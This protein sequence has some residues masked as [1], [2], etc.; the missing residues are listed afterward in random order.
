MWREGHK[1]KP[2]WKYRETT[3]WPQGNHVGIQ[4]PHCD[5]RETMWVYRN[6]IVTTGKPCGY[7]E[8]TSWPQRKH[9]GL[10][11]PHS[12]HRETMWIFR[13][14][15]DHRETMWVYRNHIVTTG[16]PCGYTKTTL[17]PQGNHVGIQK[18]HRDHKENM[19]V[20]KNHIVTTGNPC[21]YSE[22]TVTTGKPCGYTETTLWP[23][24]NHLTK[25]LMNH[26]TGLDR[27]SGFLVVEAPRFQDIRHMIIVRLSALH[28]CRLYP[29][30]IFL[31]LISVKGWVDPRAIMR[32][33]GLWK[34]P[35]NRTDDFP[36]CDAVPQPTAQPRAPPNWLWLCDYCY[37][38]GFHVPLIHS[39]P[40]IISLPK[41]QHN[42]TGLNQ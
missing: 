16:K 19:W 15:S 34:I 20:Y 26:W 32:P 37:G 1:K 41:S 27:P 38:V 5:H 12:E 25:L 40:I 35:V 30:E 9:V 29:Q 6:H 3:L 28:T 14:H 23:Q 7:T 8:T 31:L 24:G 22:T 33:E 11:K 13:N 17:W 39:K 10:Q 2:Y 4:K 18:P 42:E 36:G 21:G